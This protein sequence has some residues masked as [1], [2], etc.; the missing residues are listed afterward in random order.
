MFCLHS[1]PLETPFASALRRFRSTLLACSTLLAVYTG[2]LT[3]AAVAADVR[4]A[5]TAADLTDILREPNV[6]AKATNVQVV[7]AGPDVTVLAQ[8]E[9][10][11][12]DRDLKIDA[13]FLA[14]ALFQGAGGQISKVKVLF[15]QAGHDG[16]Y[17]SVTDRQIS[18]YGSGKMAPEQFLATL[19][20]VPVEV[21]RA[22]DVVP[23]SQFERRLL[24][25]QRIEKL[26]QQG[27]G[28]IPFE[29]IFGEVE[30]SIKAGNQ[31]VSK[32]LSFLESKLAD[33]EEALKQAKNAARGLGVPAPRNSLPSSGAERSDRPAS[34]NI[35]QDQQQGVQR[36]P[37]NPEFVKERFQARANELINLARGKD[38][39]AAENMTELKKKADTAFSKNNLLEAFAY[40]HQ[41]NLITQKTIGVNLFAP[42]R[43]DGPPGSGSGSGGGPNGSGGGPNGGDG[44][45]NGGGGGPNGGGG[46]NGGS[47]GGPP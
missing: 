19:R 9:S 34:G 38:L 30:A 37:A 44:G 43:G 33:Q 18:D 10:A 45:P 4:P 40:I 11:S 24:I 35:A 17:I 29:T 7:G 14:K 46:L 15:S 32:R 36:L 3:S 1:R 6:G 28:V 8:T 47:G 16:R 13:I 42:G 21:E 2:C 25:W 41:F 26:R 20:L 31:D 39:S 27:T 12:A 22:P 5:K 23:G